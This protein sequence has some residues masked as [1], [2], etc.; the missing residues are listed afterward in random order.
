MSLDLYLSK[1]VF[2]ANITHNLGKMADAAGIYLP[3]W[4]P[5]EVGIYRAG[6]LVE[7]LREGLAKLRAEPARF[8]ALDSPNGWGTYV[9][10]VPFV[11]KVYVAALEHPDATVRAS[12]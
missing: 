2:S 10:F 12:R 4:R 7:P 3:L 11:E 1:E 8:A 6:E 5:E 9:H